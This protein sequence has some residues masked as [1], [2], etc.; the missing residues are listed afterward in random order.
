MILAH[1]IIRTL[2]HPTQ[3]A[4]LRTAKTDT[5]CLH[6]SLI[7]P[8][9]TSLNSKKSHALRMTI[10]WR[11]EEQ[12]LCE[13]GFDLKAGAPYV[14]RYLVCGCPG[15]IFQPF[16]AVD[17]FKIPE[18]AG[19][20]GLHVDHGQVRDQLQPLDSADIVQ[21]PVLV[22]G[23]AYEGRQ[24]LNVL[25]RAIHE[26]LRIV[27]PHKERIVSGGV[28]TDETVS[29]LHRQRTE[30]GNRSSE[31]QVA[32]VRLGT[33]EAGGIGRRE[34]VD[35]SQNRVVFADTENGADDI[36]SFPYPV[37]VAVDVNAEQ[38]DVASEAGT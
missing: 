5:H 2:R 27:F 26:A 7:K 15:H 17:R 25:Q 30:R 11:N 10:L 33:I 35:V 24:R 12:K 22:S 36:E 37:I 32:V 3:L 18:P 16:L 28:R 19:C 34:G 23:L 31:V 9:L 14:R 20:T 21:L 38:P 8:L 13:L 29:L 6:S 4:S 1:K